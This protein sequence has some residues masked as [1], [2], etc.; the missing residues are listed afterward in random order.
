MIDKETN[1]FFSKFYQYWIVNS[2]QPVLYYMILL[3]PTGKRYKLF[4]LFKKNSNFVFSNSA[5][6]I[7]RY[8]PT[9]LTHNY[10]N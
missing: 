6:S 1:Y 9:Y 4:L 3:N 10:H 2:I 8:L 5:L 7:S